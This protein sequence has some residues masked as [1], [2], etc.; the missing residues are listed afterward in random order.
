MFMLPIFVAGCFT[1]QQAP[2][3]SDTNTSVLAKLNKNEPVHH[4]LWC[5]QGSSKTECYFGQ[6]SSVPQ[7]YKELCESSGGEV[8][9]L[10]TTCADN[11]LHPTE[12]TGCGDAPGYACNCG[13]GMCW[14]GITC[15]T[16]DSQHSN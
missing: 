10:G 9:L 14:D 12:H 6:E 16:G 4:Y 2:Q 1:T 8:T 5:Q 7:E 13:D 3:T 15:I 11:C